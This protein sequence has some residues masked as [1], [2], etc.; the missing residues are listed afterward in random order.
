MARKKPIDPDDQDRVRQIIQDTPLPHE[1]NPEV[2]ALY[3]K[4]FVDPF[5]KWGFHTKEG[6][7]DGFIRKKGRRKDDSEYDMPFIRIDMQVG[8]GEASGPACLERPTVRHRQDQQGPAEALLG[9]PAPRPG[10]GPRHD[11]PRQ[12]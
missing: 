3:C 11:R 10:D 7:W 2:Y 8:A 4:H 9:R 12:P 1:Q 6:Y 5:A